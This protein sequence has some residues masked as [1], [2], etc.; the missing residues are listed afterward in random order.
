[1]RNHARFPRLAQ[2]ARAV[3][4]TGVLSLWDEGSEL[5]GCAAMQ[6]RECVQ[7]RYQRAIDRFV[8][9]TRALR[10][11]VSLH[12]LVPDGAPGDS[13]TLLV[14]GPSDAFACVTRELLLPRFLAHLSA[15]FRVPVTA[16]RRVALEQGAG[17][18]PLR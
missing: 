5:A 4:S 3:A 2:S 11:A 10:T 9:E 18:V 12:Q 15:T 13:G 17:D 16:L 14:H 6:E 8:L 1:M 7:A